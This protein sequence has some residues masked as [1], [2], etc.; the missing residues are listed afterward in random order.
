VLQENHEEEQRRIAAGGVK[1]IGGRIF[2]SK[3]KRKRRKKAAIGEGGLKRGGIGAIPEN[4][5]K[6]DAHATRN[7]NNLEKIIFS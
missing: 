3:R 6:G 2:I 4:K 7:Q 1:N 5:W